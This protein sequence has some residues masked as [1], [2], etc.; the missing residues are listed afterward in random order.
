[1]V[2]IGL[3]HFIPTVIA[4]MRGH[5]SKWAILV[6]NVLLGWSGIGWIIALVWSLT[7]VKK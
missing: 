1:M 5:Q 2:V 4:F 7:G 6:L 3:L